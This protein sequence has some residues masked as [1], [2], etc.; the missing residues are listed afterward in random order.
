MARLPQLAFWCTV[1]LS[2]I[3]GCGVLSYAPAAS[4]Q[5]AVA[6]QPKL[7]LHQSGKFR[8]FYYTQGQHAVY[9]ADWNRNGVPDQVEDLLTQTLA[10]QLLFVD[11]LGFPDPF[12][13]ERFQSASFLDI[14]MRHKDVLKR[15]GVAYDELQTFKR[16]KDPE[17]TQSL[18]FNV[19]TSVRPSVEYTP[20]HEFFH[21]VQ[22]GITFFKNP[23][24]TEGTARWSE[25]AL[26]KG[27]M[28]AAKLSGTWPPSGEKEAKLFSMKYEAS[29]QFWYPLLTRIETG[30]GA[31]PESP[32]LKHLAAM[33][34][35][36]GTRVLKD[37]QLK[38]WQFIRDVLL[39]LGQADDVAFRE[40]GYDGW[41]EEN[42][43]SPK[44]DEYI[45]RAVLT[46]ARRYGAS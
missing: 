20:T 33:T 35:A 26:G 10:A 17:G 5:Y 19:A 36:D 29:E 38:G 30:G 9:P 42:Q 16:R 7:R 13:T 12:T 34:Y 44:N 3:V 31:L 40:L 14:H 41:T 37:K 28:G 46:V 23:W 27:G 25:W 4:A 45:L 11:V 8:V 32:A 18:C 6:V 15:K 22:N 1:T 24:Y 43:R 39:E 21:I 2:C